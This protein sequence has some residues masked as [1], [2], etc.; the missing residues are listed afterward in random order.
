MPPV[1]SLFKNKIKIRKDFTCF[2][3]FVYKI[4]YLASVAERVRI[5]SATATASD[6]QKVLPVK[7]ENAEE[8]KNQR[9]PRTV[10][11]SYVA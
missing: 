4:Y 6:K 10:S 7:T 8:K 11:E 9:L 5:L 1:R 2:Q 3:F